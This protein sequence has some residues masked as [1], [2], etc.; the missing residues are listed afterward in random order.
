[1]MYSEKAQIA[2][3]RI[4]RNRMGEFHESIRDELIEALGE[5]IKCDPLSLVKI[6]R[7]CDAEFAAWMGFPFAVGVNSGTSALVIALHGL[8]VQPGDEV[9]TVANS[10]MADTNAIVAVGAVPVLCDVKPDDY[11][12]DPEKLEPLITNKTKVILPVDLY[13]NPADIQRIREIA[14]QYGI[15]VLQDAALGIFSR[16]QGKPA[17]YFADAVAF[18]T[19]TTKLVH[20][21]GYGGY[22][23]SR[24]PALEKKCRLFTEYG[25]DEDLGKDD[26]YSGV[27]YHA[28]N[29]LNVKMNAADAV[30][31]RCKLKYFEQFRNLRKQV[32]NWY[33]D[34]LGNI[35]NIVLPKFC[36]RADPCV[37]E[38]VIRVV[39]GD[40]ND[41]KVRNELC[42]ALASKGV[43]ST[44]AFTPCVHKR[45]I[46]RSHI[47]AG[48]ENVPVSEMLDGQ[49]LS[50]PCDITTTE[51]NVR[52]IADIIRKFMAAGHSL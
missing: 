1:M 31:V 7:K 25:V 36:E 47:W 8:G 26:P 5:V 3:G 11:T 28:E 52:F 41:G 15:K 34:Y 46:G 30:A 44:L 2:D 33:E 16:Y 9:I 35:P 17:G 49:L 10:D 12:M 21:L 13:G 4:L 38:Y 48:A 43:Q 42:S 20:G 37:R 40:N 51:D 23:C 39:S 27:K 32:L 50:L 45:L 18:S 19:S 22:V 29:G 6:I 24:D 14:D